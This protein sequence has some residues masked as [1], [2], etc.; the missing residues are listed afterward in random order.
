MSNEE[1]FRIIT[2]RMTQLYLL[3]NKNYGNSYHTT[4]EEYGMT[5]PLI[6]I[7][8]KFKRLKSLVKQ[9]KDANVDD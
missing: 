7:E 5:V 2:E 1:K 4:F 9:G 3:K 6:R 8:D